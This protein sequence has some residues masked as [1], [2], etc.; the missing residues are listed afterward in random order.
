MVCARIIHKMVQAVK[1]PAQEM[2]FDLLLIAVFIKLIRSCIN[3]R[4]YHYGLYYNAMA[5]SGLPGKEN[6]IIRSKNLLEVQNR[7]HIKPWVFQTMK[8]TVLHT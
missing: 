2:R 3:E 6:C 1:L 4:C 5:A 8:P 7:V